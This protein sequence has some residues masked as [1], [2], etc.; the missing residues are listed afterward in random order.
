MAIGL[1]VLF[2]VFG[3]LTSWAI[4]LST[5]A[6]LRERQLLALHAASMVGNWLE[7]ALRQ[8]EAFTPY[9]VWDRDG[10]RPLTDQPA[11]TDLMQ[12]VEASWDLGAVGGGG[13][14]VWAVGGWSR[15]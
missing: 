9:V 13:A 3:G 7:R 6:A 2:G 5:E 15:G 8:L 10:T 11:L 14:T 12:L 1:I 4:Q